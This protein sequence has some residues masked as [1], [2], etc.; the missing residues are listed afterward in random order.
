MYLQCVTITKRLW[1]EI[2]VLDVLSFC[3]AVWYNW[4]SKSCHV[5]PRQC[6]VD[7]SMVCVYLSVYDCVC[8]CVCVEVC[9]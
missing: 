2:C 3:P 9:V 4:C 6:E 1:E 5:E 8:V 7:I